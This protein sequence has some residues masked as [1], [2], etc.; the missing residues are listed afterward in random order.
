MGWRCFGCGK[1]GDAIA[2]VM[3]RRGVGLCEAVTPWVVARRRCVLP[4]W[5]GQVQKVHTSHPL[6]WV[7]NPNRGCGSVTLRCSLANWNYINA[8]VTY[9]G[10]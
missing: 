5:S 3:E 10:R 8:E 6:Q 7:G 4:A 9:N 1:S 2:W